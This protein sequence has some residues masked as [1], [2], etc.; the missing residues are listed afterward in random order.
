MKHA[1]VGVILVMLTM[2]TGCASVPNPV[3]EAYNFE[4]ESYNRRLEDFSKRLAQHHQQVANL[5]QQDTAVQIEWKALQADLAAIL[6]PTM[7]T[8]LEQALSAN[9]EGLLLAWLNV[10]PDDQT[11]AIRRIGER[12]AELRRRMDYL[13][14]EGARLKEEGARLGEEDKRL[15]TER[16]NLIER[17]FALTVAPPLLLDQGPVADYMRAQAMWQAQYEME[18]QRLEQVGREYRQQQQMN[19][20]L[21]ILQQQQWQQQQ[22][23]RQEFYQSLPISPYRKKW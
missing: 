13:Q 2:L 11:A 23:Q 16:A 12:G 9:D 7:R 21:N 17:Q 5:N 20:M 22:Q 18:R 3:V 4:V 6:S 15:N 8:T 10:L 14:Q 19:Q 1:A